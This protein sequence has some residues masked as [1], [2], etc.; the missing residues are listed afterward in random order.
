VP[1]SV[2]LA[3]AIAGQELPSSNAAFAG[4]SLGFGYKRVKIVFRDQNRLFIG[5]QGLADAGGVKRQ[6]S[7]WL[8]NFRAS[9]WKGFHVN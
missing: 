4:Q 2:D 7:A 9:F 6:F 3:L 5:F 1:V 8:R